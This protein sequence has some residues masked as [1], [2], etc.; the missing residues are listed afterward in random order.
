M[1]NET[2]RSYLWRLAEANGLAGQDLQL[3]LTGSTKK[4]TV[5]ADQLAAITGRSTD[6]LR[7]A[8][9]ELCTPAD[10]AGM[11]LAG[12]PRPGPTNWGWRWPHNRIRVACN[13]CAARRDS[14]RHR[15]AGAGR[16]TLHTVGDALSRNRSTARTRR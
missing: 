3:Y 14:P 5:T 13:H 10:L 6:T 16:L 11:R 9:P 8:M 15:G 4:E 12:R 1:L 7:Y 2:V